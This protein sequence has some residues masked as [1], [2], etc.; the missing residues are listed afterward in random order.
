MRTLVVGDIHGCWD[1]FQDLLDKAGVTN[2]DQIIAIGDLVNRGPE[3][4]KVLD[5]FR[6]KKH[7]NAQAI[8]GNHERGHLKVAKGKGNKQPSI[9]MMY[10]RWQLGKH[11][12]KALDY[13]ASLPMYI[14]LPSALLVHAYYEPTVRLKNQRKDVIIGTMTA[15][16]YLKETYKY[17]WYEL[18]DYDKPLIC[19]HRDWSGRMEVFNHKDRVYGIDTRCVY[20]GSLTGMWLP[21]F[22]TVSIPARDDHWRTFRKNVVQSPK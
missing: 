20:G 9:S 15:E 13:M 1:E 7:P 8:I 12:D 21:D 14:K 5:F 22:T 17:P 18:Y 6:K 2:D 10:T 16:Q 3:S 19:G 11:Y 4:K